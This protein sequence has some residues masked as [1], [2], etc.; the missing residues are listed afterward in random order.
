MRRAVILLVGS[1]EPLWRDLKGVFGRRGYDIREAAS[2]ADIHRAL[3][4]DTADLLLI[5]PSPDTGWNGLE[6]ARQIRGKDRRIPVI[7]IVGASSEELAIAALRAGINDYFKRPLVLDDLVASITRCLADVPS[8]PAPDPSETTTAGGAPLPLL[9]G[10]SVAIREINLYIGMVG[11]TDSTV[12]ITGETGTGKEVTAELVHRNSPR[13]HKPFVCINCAAIP[14]SLLESELFGFERGAFTGAHA[15]REGRLKLADG[16]TAF[17]DEIGD[18]T[19][20]GQAKILRVIEGKE[21]HRLGAKARVPLDVRFIAA[22]NQDLER[23]VAEGRFRK[24][25]YYRLNVARIHLPPLRERKEDIPPLF[26]HY[27]RELNRRL[28][29]EVEGLTEDALE[30]L[31]RYEWPGNVRELKNFLE[32]MF[33]G[34]SSQRISFLDLPEQFR[35]RLAE[36][37]GLPEDERARMLSALLTTRW[38]KSKAAQKLNWSRMTLYRK[39]AK[40]QIVTGSRTEDAA[41]RIPKEEL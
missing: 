19:P 16:G 1:A 6:L 38:N 8:P 32:A 33:I 37:D 9:I 2:P 22:T 39:M 5:G 29:R 13:R 20:E 31:L 17:F 21:V 15:F 7:L 24:D 12:L 3:Q 27:I 23:R 18:M 30:P 4:G 10:D 36:T 35:R 26:D 14:D 40:Y 34:T 28:G 11:S 25:L 41:A